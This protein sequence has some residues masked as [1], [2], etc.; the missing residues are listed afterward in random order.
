MGGD[1]GDG[2]AL[3]E[4]FLT[5]F[6]GEEFFNELEYSYGGNVKEPM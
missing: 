6:V 4:G 3:E 5:F 2:G 1:A